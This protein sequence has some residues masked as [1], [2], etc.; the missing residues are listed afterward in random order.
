ML[1]S[2]ELRQSIDVVYHLYLGI[3]HFKIIKHTYFLSKLHVKI[4]QFLNIVNDSK[5]R[6]YL[7]I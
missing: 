7:I 5:N 4:E 2:H 3:G 6:V 1:T